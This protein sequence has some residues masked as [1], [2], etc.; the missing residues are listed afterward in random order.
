MRIELGAG[1]EARLR[2]SLKE[3]R[4]REIGGMLF[5]EQ[6]SPGIFKIVDFSVDP[7]SGSNA[8]FERDPVQHRDALNGFFEK[9]GHDYQRFNYL[10]EWH[11]HPSFSV[12]P[13][14]RDIE[15]M[16]E[17][18]SAAGSPITFAL[19]L[20]VRLRYFGSIDHSMF[21]FARG[22]QPSKARLRARWI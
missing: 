3:A 13:S 11:S 9:T 14:T 16:T 7:N 2:R 21:A 19:L 6:L 1:V 18:V 5:A 22:Q 17:L 10:G 12:R 4:N 8:F 20:I 15:T